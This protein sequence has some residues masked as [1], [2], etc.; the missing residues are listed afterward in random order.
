M[1]ID[2]ILKS[3]VNTSVAGIYRRILGPEGSSLLDSI[4]VPLALAL[5]LNSTVHDSAK[6]L[7]AKVAQLLILA[8]KKWTSSNVPKE[9]PTTEWL[10]E[11]LLITLGSGVYQAWERKDLI[12]AIYPYFTWKAPIKTDDGVTDAIFDLA[13]LAGLTKPVDGSKILPELF[14]TYKALGLNEAAEVARRADA[15]MNAE[16]PIVFAKLMLTLCALILRQ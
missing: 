10:H 8:T 9:T 2:T 5:Q 15:E 11:Y 12:W 1:V 14:S 13:I 6:S 4:L 16:A 7:N 3:T